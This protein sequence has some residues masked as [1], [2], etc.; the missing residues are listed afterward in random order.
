MAFDVTVTAETAERL[1]PELDRLVAEFRA[2]ARM[3]VDALPNPDEDD[4]IPDEV[5]AGGRTWWV[6]WHDPHYCCVD[7]AD[8]V[9][10][11]HIYY[12]DL[13]DPWFL[14]QYA[15]TAGGHDAVV[16]ACPAGFHDIARLLDL[17]GV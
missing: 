2:M 4:D 1:R 12:P 6:H 17:H 10:E 7:E 3:L 11:A 15:Q 13:V 14:L 16:E 8:V 9:V 5:V